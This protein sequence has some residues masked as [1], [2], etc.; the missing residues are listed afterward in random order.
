MQRRLQPRRSPVDHLMYAFFRMTNHD[1]YSDFRARA[2]V[3]AVYDFEQV[4]NHFPNDT[5]YG[6]APVNKTFIQH[7]IVNDT[8]YKPGGPVF[9]LDSGE[10]SA[11]SRFD[12]LLTGVI[13]ELAQATKYVLRVCW[14]SG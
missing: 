9:L 14:I 3:P 6:P 8:F 13:A 4:T 10:T 1:R 5:F 2:A 7:Y 11:Q 12:Y